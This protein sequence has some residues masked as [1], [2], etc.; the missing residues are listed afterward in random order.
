MGVFDNL[1]QLGDLKS[2]RDQ[3][4]KIQ[5]VLGAETIE[6]NKGS[7]RILISGDQKVQ[8]VE[9]NGQESYDVKDAINE[10]IK[11]SQ[12]LAAK[13]MMEMNV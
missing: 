8:L 2:M 4:V 12:E 5:R 7:V 6:V 9:I 11:K 13:K 3:A 1:R 10:A